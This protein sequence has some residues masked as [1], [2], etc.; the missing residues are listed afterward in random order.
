MGT[1]CLL[2]GAVLH[3]LVGL[4][5]SGLKRHEEETGWA[6]VLC[7]FSQSLVISM[8]CDVITYELPTSS[9]PIGK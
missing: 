9:V 6:C 5:K 2:E 7:M 3:H 4:R 8:S 1:I